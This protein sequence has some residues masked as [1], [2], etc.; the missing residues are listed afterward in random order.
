MAEGRGLAAGGGV[1]GQGHALPRRGRFLPHHQPQRVHG[2]NVGEGIQNYLNMAGFQET[3][4]KVSS[5]K[6]F[7][8]K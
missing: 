3:H 5:V 6:V 1:K 4:I 7:L 8:V 2:R